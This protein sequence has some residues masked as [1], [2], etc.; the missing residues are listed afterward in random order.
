MSD[1][2]T[3]RALSRNETHDLSMI[4]KD[5]AKVLKAHV[6]EQ[7]TA[8]LADFEQKLAAV[9][10]FDE[11]EVW[12]QAA[13]KAQEVVA[14]AQKVIA[15]RCKELGIPKDF[16]PGLD[17]TW[18]GRGQNALNLRRIE[19]RRVAKAS[20]EAM[21]AAAV[22]KIERQSL[23]LRTQIVAMGL[24]S[25][26]AKLFLDS[27]APVEEMMR[28]LQFDDIERKLEIERKRPRGMLGYGH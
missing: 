19:L 22:A 4:I 10:S 18:H 23:D 27:L 8:F 2:Q 17:I 15:E 20:V 13:E 26:E 7:A 16:A 3:P 12:R 1:S 5:R 25:A 6:A 28:A 11:D 21:S 14:S 9:Y 24:L